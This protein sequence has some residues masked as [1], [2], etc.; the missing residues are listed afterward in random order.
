MSETSKEK[1]DKLGKRV[2]IIYYL[3]I[4]ATVCGIGIIAYLQTSINWVPW[5]TGMFAVIHISWGIASYLQDSAVDECLIPYYFV[6]MYVYLFPAVLILWEG[7][8]HFVLALYVLLPLIIPS[9]RYPLKHLIASSISSIFYVVLLF[10][11]SACGCVKIAYFDGVEPRVIALLNTI[12]AVVALSGFTLFIYCYCKI[13]QIMTDE[14]NKSVI[15]TEEKAETTKDTKQKELHNK[16]IVY[17]ETKQPYKQAQYNLPMLASDLDTNTKYISEV[18]SKYYG[19]FNN[20]LNKYRLE[21]VKKMLEE[22]LTDTYTMEYIYT[23]AGYSSHSAFYSN[24]YKTF[25]ATPLEFQ[26]ML[27]PKT[28]VSK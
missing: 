11:M 28:V 22:R 21:L 9:R 8:V 18:I 20:L 23:L 26:R 7:Q 1:I 2:M 13:F 15:E 6:F 19:S 5:Y 27:K 24:F 17:F 10:V 14:N 12:I 16:I 3:L 25:Q 4:T